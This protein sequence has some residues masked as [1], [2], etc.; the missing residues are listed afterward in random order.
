MMRPRNILPPL[1]L[2]VEPVLS[3]LSLVL[4]FLP[5]ANQHSQVIEMSRWLLLHQHLTVSLPEDLLRREEE[6]HTIIDENLAFI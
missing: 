3:Q 2:V 1:G 4:A 6:G 5:A